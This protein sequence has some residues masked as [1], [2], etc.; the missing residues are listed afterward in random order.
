MTKNQNTEAVVVEVE[1]SEEELTT[2][3]PIQ[4][5]QLAGVRPQMVYNYIKAGYIEATRDEE[6]GKLRVDIEVANAWVEKYH[7]NKAVREEKR[8]AKLEAELAGEPTSEA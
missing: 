4:V 8:Q 7:T 3:S 2:L 1:A 6:S 5:A